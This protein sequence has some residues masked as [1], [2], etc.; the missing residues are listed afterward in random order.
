MKGARFDTFWVVLI[1]E[2]TL[3][4]HF[5]M[6][7]LGQKVSERMVIHPFL[8]FLLVE[9]AFAAFA[10]GLLSVMIYNSPLYDSR[11]SETAR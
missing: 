6:W 3:L 5:G 10:V 2:F 1:L 11:N 4:C 7:V 8:G 9:V